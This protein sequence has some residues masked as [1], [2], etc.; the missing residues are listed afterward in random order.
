MASPGV[1]GC[2]SQILGRD[3]KQVRLLPGELRELNKSHSETHMAPDYLNKSFRFRVHGTPVPWSAPLVGRRGARKDPRLIEWQ[4]I[5]ANAAKECFGPHEPYEGPVSLNI[6]F[7]I[8]NADRSMWGKLIEP[9][10]TWNENHGKHKKQ[11][12]L[13]DRTNLIK[14]VEDAIE[15]VFFVNDTQVRIG[16]DG[17]FWAEKPGCVVTVGMIVPGIMCAP[18]FCEA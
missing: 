6:I 4:G 1:R 14:G 5:V 10:I 3:H 8:H 2:T 11:G 16:S 7:L 17:C 15:G 13:A 18:D 12:G 9:E